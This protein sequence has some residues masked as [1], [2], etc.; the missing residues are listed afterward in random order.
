MGCNYLSLPSIP[1]SGITLPWR[2]DKRDGISNHQCIGCLLN[3]LFRRR[4]EKTSKLRV[5]GLCEGNP[6]VTGGFPLQRASNM[7]N[8]SIWWH[9]HDITHMLSQSD[10]IGCASYVLYLCMC[11]LCML[12]SNYYPGTLVSSQVFTTDLKIRHISLSLYIYIIYI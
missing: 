12:S 2:H 8:V 3:R 1:A 6:P 7:E 9:H 10:T 5:T 11:Y 4:S